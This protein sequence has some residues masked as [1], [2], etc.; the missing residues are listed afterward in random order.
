MR[1]YLNTKYDSRKSFYGKAE[2]EVKDDETKVL[3]SYGYKA[4][5]KEPNGKLIVYP[6]YNAS[7]TTLR[8]VKEFLKQEG[9]GNTVLTSS[10]IL[11]FVTLDY[12][13][14]IL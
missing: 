14:L 7:Q 10:N 8:H 11:N 12:S 5:K 1:Y 2:V 4:A 13:D 6:N 3:Y 9:L